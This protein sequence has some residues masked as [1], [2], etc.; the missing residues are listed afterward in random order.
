M[1]PLIGTGAESI[2]P[3]WTSPVRIRSHALATGTGDI[4]PRSLDTLVF[5]GD[6]IDRGRTAG[7]YWSR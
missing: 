5:L 1:L 3:S 2:F 6:Y 7:A 4:A